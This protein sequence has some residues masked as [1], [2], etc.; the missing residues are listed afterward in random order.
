MKNSTFIKC[1]AL[2]ISAA[3]LSACAHTQK[4]ADSE[5]LT[6]SF[7]S[8]N[9][10]LTCNSLRQEIDFAMTECNATYFNPPVKSLILNIHK[11]R[12]EIPN[13]NASFMQEIIKEV[14]EK[15]SLF[16]KLE[17][18]SCP[19]TP[20]RAYTVKWYAAED[21]E[22]V[23]PL[24]TE[25]IV[26]YEPSDKNAEH[27]LLWGRD[28]GWLQ[29]SC[30]EV[31]DG[32]SVCFRKLFSIE[33]LFPNLCEITPDQFPGEILKQAPV[34]AEDLFDTSKKDTSS[35]NKTTL[36]LS[37]EELFGDINKDEYGY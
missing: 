35:K 26:Y 28:M 16:G 18:V 3:L 15:D 34:P 4:K 31:R 32:M 19:N 23:S 12:F 10:P 9:I 30:K 29:M 33:E 20:V 7:T 24:S 37:R 25:F 14:E 1:A 2:C 36:P 5:P 17:E 22:Q 8:Q 11:T 21:T 13:I 6:F 27:L